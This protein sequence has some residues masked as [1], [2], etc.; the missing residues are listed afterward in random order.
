MAKIKLKPILPKKIIRV[1]R[2]RK[3]IIDTLRKSGERLEGNFER[4]TSTWKNKP[5]F[6]T[7]KRFNKEPVSIRVSTK[8]KI[9][10]FVNNG[11]KAHPI[12][13]KRA[14]A[15][16]FQ[17]TYKAKTTPGLISSRS[18]GA[19]GKFVYAKKIKRHPGTKPRNFAKAIAEKERK[20]L[21]RDI[22]SAIMRGAKLK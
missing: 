18:G 14:K 5:D 17:P 16:R 20:L 22:K 10:R 8:D 2:M 7:R 1:P 13:P 6:K 21:N 3:E 15:L 12:V 9:Y 11:T 4:T 19:S